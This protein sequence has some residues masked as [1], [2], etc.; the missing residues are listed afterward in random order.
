MMYQP[1]HF[2]PQELVDRHYYA[3]FGERAVEFIDG[4]I[5]RIVDAV[6]DLFG[7]PVY[8]NDWVFD[9]DIQYRGLRSF[10]CNVG[11]HYSMHKYGRAIDFVVQGVPSFQVRDRLVKEY[12]LRRSPFVHI[13]RME[14]LPV[15]QST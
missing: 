11:A 4:R 14:V 15:G 3:R 7:V 2:K 1:K 6:R 5:L 8:V 9:G 10:Y 12:R 13:R